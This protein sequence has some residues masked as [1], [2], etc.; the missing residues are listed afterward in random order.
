VKLI[1]VLE[2]LRNSDA[3]EWEHITLEHAQP[4]QEVFVF[5]NDCDLR[6]VDHTNFDAEDRDFREK[7]TEIFP[8][9]TARRRRYVVYHG[10]SPVY[11]T[12]LVAVDGG[13][14]ILP[15]PNLTTKEIDPLDNAVATAVN[16]STSDYSHHLNMALHALEVAE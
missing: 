8:D 12:M 1:D 15:L 3:L 6:I 10:S 13:R 5:K 14:A 7:W 11:A 2:L 4:P 16:H 9:R